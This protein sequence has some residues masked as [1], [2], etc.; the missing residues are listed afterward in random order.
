MADKK[1]IG[2][3]P[4]MRHRRK[5]GQESGGDDGLDRST[6]GTL[7][8]LADEWLLR[9]AERNYSERSVDTH[10][11]ALKMFLEWARERDLVDPDNITR[12]HLESYQRHLFRYRKKNGEPLGVTTQRNRLG[13]LKRFFAHLTRQAHIPANPAADLDLPRKPHTGLPKG[14]SR[15]QLA[16]VFA[17]PDVSDP[18]GIRDRAILEM[19][20][21]TGAR[22]S[23]L[24][25]FDV[26]D[27]DLQGATAHIRKGKGGK[28]RLVP[29][30]GD[31]LHWLRR[32]L[33]ETRPRLA[34]AA[35]EQALF[36]SGYGTRLNATYIGNWVTK[37]VKAADMGKTGSCHLM[38]HSCATH[39]YE[40]GADIRLIQQFLGHSS[41]D[42]TAIY[43]EVA[44]THLKEVYERTHPAADGAKAA[45]KKKPKRGEK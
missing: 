26:A 3:V 14:L 30:A 13:A 41:L 23:E 10:R 24:T 32:Y 17:V 25:N 29:V 31:A 15:E 6:P 36:V 16:A 2:N 34:L 38:R 43:T 33:E 1:G 39:M 7:A 28:S 40:N 11:W 22:R 18:L 5:G 27:I 21:A 37:T 9:L 20:Y 35:D 19:F 42:T 8:S 12:Q 44:I 45:I 4:G